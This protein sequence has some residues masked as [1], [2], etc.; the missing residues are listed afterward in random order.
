MKKAA[1]VMLMMAT[2]AGARLA[3]SHEIDMIE[4]ISGATNIHAVAGAGGL[5]IGVSRD[6]DLTVLTWPSPSYTDQLSY[7]TSNA[8][9]ARSEPR[10]GAAEGMGAFTAI[11]YTT[12][13]GSS[14][15]EVSWLRGD[16]WTSS[17][18][19]LDQRSS[20]ITTTY[21]SASLGL[22]VV[23]SDFVD[24]VEDAWVRRLEV[25][26]EPD[27][28]V[29]DAWALLYANLS[30]TLSRIPEVPLADWAAEAQN[31]F[32]AVWDDEAGAIVHFHPEDTGVLDEV[33]GLLIQARKDYGPLGDALTTAGPVTA[34]TAATIAGAL[35]SD[36]AEGVYLALSA[37][38]AP[39]GFQVGFDRTDL[40]GPLDVLADN[41]T[42][43]PDRY[44]DFDEG[45]L[46]DFGD[47]IRC[48]EGQHPGEAIHQRVGW[49]AEAADAFADAADGELSGSPM[50]AGHVNEALRA[51]LVFGEDAEEHQAEASFFL[52]AGPTAAAALQALDEVRTQPAAALQAATAQAHHD[53]IEGLRLP[54]PERFDPLVVDFAAR[55]LLNIRVGTD[56]NTGAIVASISRQPPYGQD[57]PRD[58]AFFNLALDV[59]GQTELVTERL[60]FYAELQ[61]D[62]QVEP[63]GLIDKPGPGFPDDPDNTNYPADAWEMNYYADGLVGGNIRWEIDNTALLIWSYV[64]HAGA[65]DDEAE[66]TAYLEEV[67]PTIERAADLLVSWRDETTYL[68]WPANEDDNLAFTQGLQGTGTSFGALRTAAMVARTLDH[69]DDAERWELRA[70]ELRWAINNHL[71]DPET[72]FIENVTE[73][74]GSA[75][76]GSSSWVA[77]PAQVFGPDD[78]RLLAQLEANLEQ[79]LWRLSPETTG[80]AYLTKT[81]LAVLLTHPD[82]AVREQALGVALTMIEDVADPDTLF[83]GEVFSPIDDDGDGLADRFDNRVS[84]PH[85]WAATLVYLTL[86][87]ADSPELFD[88]YEEVLS[89]PQIPEEVDPPETSED[90]GPDSGPDAGPDS[91]PDADAPEADTGPFFAGGGGCNGCSV[92]PGAGGPCPVGRLFGF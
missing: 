50:A 90:A 34:E 70:A 62:E 9:D 37:L 66:R 1:A 44:P 73:N 72:G 41:V 5:T 8:D 67:Y 55:T 84:T 74:P 59:A 39:D 6:G 12:E 38:P 68:P 19:Y 88:T 32:A 85:L 16:D 17:I 77:W 15:L 23:Q 80:G 11:V 86:M 57:W 13:A 83:L 4:H 78:A 60:R 76:T 20:V 71:Y 61:R 26:R 25:T 48:T 87:A 82:E 33:S 42:S 81:S 54:D 21:E 52:G 53:W 31:D 10:F 91:G 29:V 2:L 30:P 65:I 22:T 7:L 63:T 3:H 27:S 69:T 51:R 45:G 40:C 18:C 58:G 24:E 92:G 35:D 64:A 49:E 47:L 89:A 28:P 46:A 75:G 56:R 14:D 79:V 43:L 36:Y